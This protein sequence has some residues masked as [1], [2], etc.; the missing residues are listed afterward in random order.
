MINIIATVLFF[1]RAKIDEAFA[2]NILLPV[3][4]IAIF[5]ATANGWSKHFFGR[6]HW[7]SLLATERHEPKTF[8]HYLFS[9]QDPKKRLIYLQ[10][11]QYRIALK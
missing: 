10:R 8:A 5:T 1:I 2:Q 6:P 9:A 7:L 11:N 4:I 3:M